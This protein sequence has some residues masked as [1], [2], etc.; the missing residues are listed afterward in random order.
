M[1]KSIYKQIA[2]I[3][4][5]LTMSVTAVAQEK[6]NMAVGATMAVGAG[7]EHY[8]SSIGLGAKFQYN[9]TNPIR[10]EGS[11]TS[12]LGRDGGRLDLSV[13]AHYLFPVATNIKVYPLAGLNL[14]KRSAE[15]S[16][17]FGVNLGGGVDSKITNNLIFNTELTCKANV[18]LEVYM[19]VG[20]AYLF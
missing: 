6:G 4:A 7:S 20:V 17:R 5:V 13:N 15:I 9:V 8:N 12:L 1:K 19:S 10:L 16:N 2:I 14:I 3:I 18:D 11:V